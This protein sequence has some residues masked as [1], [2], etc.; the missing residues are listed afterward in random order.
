MAAELVLS[1]VLL[2]SVPYYQR[3]DDDVERAFYSLLVLQ[4]SQ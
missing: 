1:L 3:L 4:L 2:G